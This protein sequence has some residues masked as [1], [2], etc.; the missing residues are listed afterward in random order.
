MYTSNIRQLSWCLWSNCNFPAFS[1][2]SSQLS[3]CNYLC[4]GDIASRHEIRSTLLCKIRYVRRRHLLLLINL[5]FDSLMYPCESST[6]LYHLPLRS[7][8]AQDSLDLNKSRTSKAWLKSPQIVRSQLFCIFFTSWEK[9]RLPQYLV[10]VSVTK[11]WLGPV[12]LKLCMSM[13]ALLRFSLENPPL[14]RQE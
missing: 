2:S 12:C 13:L 7:A 1:F 4:Y 3:D 11:I 9:I 6:F 10:M 8:G 14:K 5:C